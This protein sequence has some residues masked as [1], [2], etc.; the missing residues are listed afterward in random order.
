MRDEQEEI[1]TMQ[2]DAPEDVRLTIALLK[3]MRLL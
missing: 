2:M 1:L 3:K